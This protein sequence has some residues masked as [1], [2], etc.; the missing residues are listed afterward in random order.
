MHRVIPTIRR[1]GADRLNNS[2]PCNRAVHPHTQSPIFPL[3]VAHRNFLQGAGARV[4]AHLGRVRIGEFRARQA[5]MPVSRPNSLEK[6]GA[7]AQRPAGWMRASPNPPA[8]PVAVQIRDGQV[9]SRARRTRT[10]R[11]AP[12]ISDCPTRHCA[13]RPRL[14]ALRGPGGHLARSRPCDGTL[15]LPVSAILG[16]RYAARSFSV[17]RLSSA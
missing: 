12:P 11:E 4:S 16:N 9:R 10:E 1:N 3:L 13:Y 8:P 7:G 5:P 6:Q 15:K 17:R 2:V 14:D